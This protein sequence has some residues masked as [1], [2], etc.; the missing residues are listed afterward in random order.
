[1]ITGVCCEN[2]GGSQ[3]ACY[4]WRAKYG[5]MEVSDVKRLKDLSVYYTYYNNSVLHLIK[6][7]SSVN[8]GKNICSLY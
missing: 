7:R 6:R 2:R 8:E 1:M 4:N 3:G 5:G